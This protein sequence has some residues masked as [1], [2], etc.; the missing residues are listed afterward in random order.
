MNASMV[1]TALRYGMKVPRYS[2]VN[3]EGAPAIVALHPHGV[4]IGSDFHGA[5]PVGS[6]Q[7]GTARRDP[8]QR[9]GRRVTVPVD[10]HTHHDRGGIELAEPR[11]N[12]H[13]SVAAEDRAKSPVLD[14]QHH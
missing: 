6:P 7:L 3:G 12:R 1:R 4:T 13:A 11:F 2:S 8:S 9:V 10:S 14:Q 5:V